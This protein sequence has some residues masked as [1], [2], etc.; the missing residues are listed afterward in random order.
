[1][2]VS[3]KKTRRTRKDD[4]LDFIVDYASE[5]NGVTPSTRE[6]AGALQLS[7]TRIHHLLT[8]LHDRRV[9]AWVA[10]DRYKVV[11]SE[12]EFMLENVF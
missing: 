7:Q 3:E 6:I 8:Q 10:G 9:I 12:W 4:V 2:A 11:D 5:N 1:M